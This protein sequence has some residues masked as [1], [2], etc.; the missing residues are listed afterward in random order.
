M[1]NSSRNVVLLLGSVRIALRL[2][3]MFHMCAC[4]IRHFEVARET[5]SRWLSKCIVGL[6]WVD[7]FAAM[8]KMLKVSNSVGPR[9]KNGREG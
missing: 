6:F 3:G 9:K 4:R 1:K 7:E 5:G 8:L 2:F